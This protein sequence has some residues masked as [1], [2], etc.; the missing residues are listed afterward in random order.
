MS[1]IS[2]SEMKIYS[3][4]VDEPRIHAIVNKEGKANWDITKPDTTTTAT[5]A[6]AGFK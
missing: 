4:T 5:E 1:V 6:S 2:G 3:V